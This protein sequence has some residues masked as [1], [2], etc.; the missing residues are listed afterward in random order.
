MNG[1]QGRVILVTGGGNGLGAAHCRILAAR[2]ARVFVADRD[3]AAATVIA[4]EI[5]AVAVAIDISDEASVVAAFDEVEAAAGTIEVLVNNAGGVFAPIAPAE[6]ITLEAWNRV[7]ATNLTGSWLCAR[8]AIPGMKRVGW[9]RIVNIASASFSMGKPTGL[10]PYITS[11]GGVVGL[12]RALSRELGPFGITVN[13]VAPGLVP[14][15]AEQVHAA[16]MLG[17]AKRDEIRAMVLA[18]QAIPR[19]GEPEDIAAAVAFLASDA[20]AFMTG[21]VMTVDGGWAHA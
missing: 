20:S 9:G 13:A 1:L 19:A 3:I 18:E 12:T 5:G 16:S 15:R 10:V 14:K 7:I 11:K 6:K 8:A 4:D 17:I 21:Q 2:G